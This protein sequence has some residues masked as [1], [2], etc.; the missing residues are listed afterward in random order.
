MLNMLNQ[1]LKLGNDQKYFVEVVKIH[2]RYMMDYNQIFIF[3]YFFMLLNRRFKCKK[4]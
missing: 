2:I 4:V 1:Y 3:L